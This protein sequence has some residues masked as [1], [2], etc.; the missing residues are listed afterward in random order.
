MLLKIREFAQLSQVSPR[1]LRHY[2]TLGLFTP[3]WVDPSSGYR[4]YHLEQLAQIRRLGVLR[5]LGFTVPEIRQLLATPV[6]HQDFRGLLVRKYAALQQRIAADQHCAQRLALQLAALDQEDPQMP[7][8]HPAFPLTSMLEHSYGLTDLTLTLR[9]PGTSFDVFH[10]QQNDTCAFIIVCVRPLAL[11]DTIHTTWLSGYGGH[12]MADFLLTRVGLLQHLEAQNYPTQRV[13]RTVQGDVLGSQDGWCALVMTEGAPQHP[14]A[15]TPATWHMM[16]EALARLHRIDLPAGDSPALSIGQ[17]W[18]YPPHA[19]REALHYTECVQPELPAGWRPLIQQFQHILATI[20]RTTLPQ[21]IIHGD[22]FLDNATLAQDGTIAWRQ[23][24][25]G[26]MGVAVLDLGR[27]LIGCHVPS[28]P[29]WPWTITP[30]AARI[31]AILAGYQQHRLLHPEEQQVLREAVKFGIA[32]T[33]MEHVAR[34][35]TTGWTP[36]LE[37]ILTVRQQWLAASE[38]IA[39]FANSAL[40]ESTA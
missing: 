15:D 36:K 30:N 10:A 12:T 3:V 23:W 20:Q 1:M 29:R 11:A 28:E 26:G 35:L 34:V 9:H 25:S 17:S 4:Y 18:F 7:V 31:T 8:D 2:A 13:V 33:A 22:P 39:T 21:A 38:D 6:F 27:L 19:L 5:D 40:S 37:K 14:P 24:H 16:G 32:Y